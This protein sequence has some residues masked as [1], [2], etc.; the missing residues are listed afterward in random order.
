[1]KTF[2]TILILIIIYGVVSRLIG[3]FV[4]NIAGLPGALI[5]RNSISKREPKYIFGVVVSALAH[6]YVYL[7]FMIYLIIWTKHRIDSDGFSKYLIWF[8]CMVAS[9][10]AIQQIYHTAK[11]EATE[12]PTGY[13]NPQI[14]SLLVTEVVSFFS[15]FLFVFFPDSINPL[16]SWVLKIGYPF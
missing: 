1:M 7:S 6:I 16:W 2:L 3:V 5:G 12:F 8:F 11:K 14:L 4:L 10:G 15:F 9:V 13:E